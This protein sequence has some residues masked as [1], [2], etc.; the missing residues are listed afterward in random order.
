[1]VVDLVIPSSSGHEFPHCLLGI[2]A[3]WD[4]GVDVSI[5]HQ[6]WS[7]VLQLCVASLHSW[8]LY[9]DCNAT[10]SD[11]KITTISANRTTNCQCFQNFL[12]DARGIDL[13]SDQAD[14]C[15]S[16]KLV[17][18]KPNKNT[19]NQQRY[20]SAELLLRTAEYSSCSW[21]WNRS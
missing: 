12:H 21:G 5:V 13:W 16:L 10:T 15:R 8:S 20:C 7:Q 9:G 11:C 2:H 14:H 4:P 17:C 3:P 19:T 6:F 1:M 18:W